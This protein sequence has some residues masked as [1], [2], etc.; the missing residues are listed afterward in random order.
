MATPLAGP[1]G[2]PWSWQ[3]AQPSRVEQPAGMLRLE[4]ADTR[5]VLHGQTSQAIEGAAAG[6]WLAGCSITATARLRAL[7]EVLVDGDGAWLLIHGADPEPVRQALDRVLFPADR[8]RLGPLEPVRLLRPAAE[9]TP[10]RNAGWWTLE[11]DQG[12]AL[13]G[14][15]VLRAAASLPAPLAA[16]PPLEPAAAELWRIQRGE[17]RAPGEIHDDIN[18]FEVGLADRVSLAKGCY[19]GQETL[20]KLATYNGVRRQLRRWWLA[21]AAAPPQPG[22]RLHDGA[23]ERAG[24][25]TS[26][27]AL[28]QG[29]WVGLALVRR[30][31]LEAPSLALEGGASLAVST[32]SGFVAPPVGP[33]GAS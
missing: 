31:A 19:V 1:D 14:W 16:Q 10:N 5:R 17:P 7:V 27:L 29:G 9:P 25:I 8:V 15:R 21:D 32:P 22:E 20:A 26:V 2:S 24:Q 13:G 3:P 6:R 18:P 23:G 33:G 4:G 11:N 12:W 30:Q 28:P